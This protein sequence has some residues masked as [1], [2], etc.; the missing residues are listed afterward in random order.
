MT[1]ALVASGCHAII[2]A[3]GLRLPLRETVALPARNRGARWLLKPPRAAPGQRSGGAEPFGPSILTAPL[4]V[5][6]GIWP[7]GTVWPHC[8]HR[9]QR[10]KQWHQTVPRGQARA[11]WSTTRLKCADQT[12]P[13]GQRSGPYKRQH[14]KNDRISRPRMA[15]EP[16]G[17]GRARPDHF[18][19]PPLSSGARPR[20]LQ[21]FDRCARPRLT[22]PPA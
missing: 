9:S 21:P 14:R 12:V 2:A 7:C 15:C 10:L 16:I 20:G 18:K 5:K 19:Q 3:R 22:Y 6:P 4:A 13:R 11:L 1:M 8:F 17:V